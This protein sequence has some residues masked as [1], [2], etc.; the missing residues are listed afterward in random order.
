ML[1][2]YGSN[3]TEV[4]FS[5]DVELLLITEF[6]LLDM[7]VKTGNLTTLLKTVGENHGEKK[8]T[9]NYSEMETDLEL[10]ESI[11]LLLIP[12]HENS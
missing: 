4:E 12:K 7:E 8:D 11:C 6:S 3:S 1:V 2:V 10:V 5:I 9:S